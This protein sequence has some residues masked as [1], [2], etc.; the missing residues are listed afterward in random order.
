V[1]TSK[2]TSTKPRLGAALSIAAIAMALGFSTSALALEAA[3]EGTVAIADPVGGT[4]VEE[5]SKEVSTA[6]F[7]VQ[8][9]PASLADSGRPLFSGLVAADSAP[10]AHA[11]VLASDG[12]GTSL[13]QARLTL[14]MPDRPELDQRIIF[15]AQF[16]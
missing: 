8:S 6:V 10:L 13:R 14:L 2:K 7:F 4:F 3:A 11:K 9:S 12:D 16:N 1:K 15:Y 5:L